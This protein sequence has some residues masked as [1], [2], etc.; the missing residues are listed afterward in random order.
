MVSG[1][2][3]VSGLRGGF[4]IW[5]GGWGVVGFGQFCQ[6][7]FSRVQ[8]VVSR[9]GELLGGFAGGEGGGFEPGGG[10]AVFAQ[11][12]DHDAAVLAVEPDDVVGGDLADQRDGALVFELGVLEQWF[13]RVV[14]GEQAELLGDVFEP[15]EGV[16][17]GEGLGDLGEGVAEEL[18]VGVDGGV[19]DLEDV[20]DL[21]EGV[22]ALVEFL[23]VEDALASFGGEGGGHGGFLSWHGCSVG[24]S[25]AGFGGCGGGV[26]GFCLRGDGGGA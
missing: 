2:W 20:G 13:Q 10:E 6:A 7:V 14:G 23:C 4:A 1:I 12:G 18:E 8:R 19:G 11:Q 26:G 17:V 15:L 22:S 9:L 5:S 24:D 25:V 16:L 21:A 3:V